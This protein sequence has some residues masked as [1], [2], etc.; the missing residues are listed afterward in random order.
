MRK[1]SAPQGPCL[2]G[3]GDSVSQIDLRILV[4]ML[5]TPDVL[6]HSACK[7]PCNSL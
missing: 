3:F 1:A 4:D 2:E 5:I 7:L 6:R